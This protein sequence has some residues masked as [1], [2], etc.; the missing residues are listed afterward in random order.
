MGGE[1]SSEFQTQPDLQSDVE[2][3]MSDRRAQLAKMLVRIEQQL[4]EAEA[5]TVQPGDDAAMM[6]W[7]SATLNKVRTS[8]RRLAKRLRNDQ[9]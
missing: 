6:E 4:N 8:I 9:K 3:T 7:A 1:L 2:D 5:L